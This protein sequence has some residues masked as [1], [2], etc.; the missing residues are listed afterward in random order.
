MDWTDS[1]IKH[2]YNLAREVNATIFMIFTESG[3]TYEALKKHLEYNIKNND[4]PCTGDNDNKNPKLKI[5]VTTPN[6]KTYNNLKNEKKIIPILMKYRNK[7]KST[8]IKQAIIRLFE[9]NLIKKGD[10][11]VA[12]LGTPRVLG[13]TDTISLIEISNSSF[14][15]KFYNF[16][17]SM[18]RIKRLVINEVLDIALE[19]SMEGREGKPV[20]TIFVVGDSEKVLKMSDQLIL[21]PFEGHNAVIFD[22]KVRGTIKE[23]SSVD[24]AFIIGDKGEVI[25]AGRYLDTSGGN[26]KLPL[27]L[28]ARHY[29][30]AAIS[31]YTDAIAITVS[32]S[33]GIVRIFKNG[34]IVVEINPNKLDR[35][36]IVSCV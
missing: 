20:G 33:G 29:A 23:L 28:G 1:I 25:S 17:N 15:L 36:N 34:E 21:N 32:E 22:K 5:V 7:Y 2:G 9:H 11:I 4:H 8:M 24:G 14:L 16:I 13:G 10:I 12:I 3:K 31:K 35:E 26:L 27:G 6:E 18:D 30:A 19:I